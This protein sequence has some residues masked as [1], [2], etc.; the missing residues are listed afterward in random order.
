V[1]KP[2]LYGGITMKLEKK[3]LVTLYTN[4]VKARA[5]DNLCTKMLATGKLIGFYHQSAGGEAPGVGAC[6]FLREDD[7]LYPHL[8]GH[9]IP[10]MLGKGIDIKSYLAEHAG[11]KT[12]MCKGISSFHK[13]EPEKGIYGYSG[14]IG[15]VFPLSVGF[16]L[17]AKKNGRGQVVV[18][19]FGDGG[20]NRGTL[21]EAFLMSNNWKLPIVWVCE[22]NGLAIYVPTSESHPT[23][24]I[25]D[26]AKGYGMPGAVIDGQDVIAVAEAVNAAVVRA[27]AGKGP[28]MVECKTTRYY[29]HDIGVPDLAGWKPRTKEEIDKLRERDPIKVCREN[30]MK[31]G[32]LTQ[33]DIKRID[34]EA[35]AEVEE[36]ERFVKESPVADDPECLDQ[37]LHA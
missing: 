27:R 29:E 36:A 24:N 22:N 10:H 5:Y 31:R 2:N 13:C 7:I 28:S 18:S 34:G 37:Y 14:L 9:S 33:K 32:I 3:H 23:E 17:G 6:S 16:G 19:C 25:A 35:A 20:S 12:G 4:L 15:S 21:H 1:G 26:L 11:K 8:R 30:L